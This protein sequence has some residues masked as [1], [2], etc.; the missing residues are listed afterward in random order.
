[1]TWTRGLTTCSI[2][3][4]MITAGW[5][6]RGAAGRAATQLTTFGTTRFVSVVRGVMVFALTAWWRGGIAGGWLRFGNLSGFAHGIKILGS[7]GAS[8]R[9]MHSAVNPFNTAIFTKTTLIT[10]IRRIRVISVDDARLVSGLFRRTTRRSC[11]QLSWRISVITIGEQ[12]TATTRRLALV[13]T[14]I[15][16]FVIFCWRCRIKMTLKEILEVF[17]RFVIKITLS[18]T[19][20]ILD[21]VIREGVEKKWVWLRCCQ[22]PFHNNDPAI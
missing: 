15:V 22:V 16:G 10:N 11:F 14:M 4:R 7:L 5:L 8:G 6:T 3:V 18:M 17:N 1:M 21:V 19:H 20:V 9:I 13:N 2:I 12:D